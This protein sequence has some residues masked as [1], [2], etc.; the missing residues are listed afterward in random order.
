MQ[1]VFPPSRK[2]LEKI[3]D[4][5]P[6]LIAANGTPI[7][8][9]GTTTWA[10]TILGCRYHWPFVIADV[11]FPLLDADFLGHHGL[12]V[13]FARQRLLDTGMCHS[14]Q[15][16]TG[17]RMPSICSAAPNS[18]TSLLQEFPDMF[19]PELR[20]SPGALARHGIFHHITT[21]GPPTHAK[22]RHLS[23]QKLQDAKRA[24]AEMER[25]GVCKKASSTWTSPL[26]MVK[27]SDGSWRPCGDY[28]RLNLVTTP[29]H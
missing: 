4:S 16:S 12:L 3:P 2:G 21:T 19:K 7:R 28:R 13:N 15:L 26:H 5:L 23:P 18:Y 22:F 29:D 9:Y 6:S 10:I 20:Q 27:K 11:E 1:P 17:P 25:M 24:F 8:T 14:H